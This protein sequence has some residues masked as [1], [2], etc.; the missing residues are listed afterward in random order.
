MALS[1][2]TAAYVATGARGTAPSQARAGPARRG[3]CRGV[4]TYPPAALAPGAPA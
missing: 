1:Y 3:A 2:L 4:T